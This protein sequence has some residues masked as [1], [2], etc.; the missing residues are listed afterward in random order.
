MAVFGGTS[1]CLTL[2][3]LDQVFLLSLSLGFLVCKV[4]MKVPALQGRQLIEK[5]FIMPEPSGKDLP[6]MS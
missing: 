2:G 4:R 3:D 1:I 6:V 5:T